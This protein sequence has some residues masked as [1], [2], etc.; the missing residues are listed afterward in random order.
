MLPNE[1]LRPLVHLDDEQGQG[2]VPLTLAPAK[3]DF[4]KL[5]SVYG[6]IRFLNIYKCRIVPPLLSLSRVNLREKSGHVG[7]SRGA[8]LEP[9]LVNS[10]LKEVWSCRCHFRHDGLLKNL[11]HVGPHHDGP[12][13]LQLRLVQSF[14]E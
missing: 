6:V 3:Q 5:L 1:D 7:S 12:D 2:L 14:I 9:R 8:L 13:V 10:S 4:P 11:R